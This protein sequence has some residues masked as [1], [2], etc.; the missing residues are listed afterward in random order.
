MRHR[1]LLVAVSLIALLLPAALADASS[2][3]FTTVE[4]P[5]ELLY[6]GSPNAALDTIKDLGATAIRVQLIWSQVAPDP[7]ATRAPSFNQTDPNAYPAGAWARWDAAIDGARARGLK[8][9][10]TITGPAPRWATAAKRDGLTKPDAEAFSK[11][12]SAAGRRYGSKVSWW[13]IWNEPNLGKLLKPIKG[14]QSATIYR[15]LYLQAYSGL[16]SVGVHAPILLGELAPIGNTFRDQGTIHPLQFLRKVLCL[17]SRWHKSRKCGKVPTQGFA[18]HPY[19]PR[20]GPTFQPQN[21]DDVTIGVLSRLV[22]ALDRAAKAGALPRR[23]PVYVSEFG[24]QSYPDTQFGVRL[25]TQSDFRSIGERMA[26]ANP[27]VKSFSQYLLRDDPPTPGAHGKFE[28]GLFLYKGDVP[29]PAY[30][31]FRLPLVVAKGKHG[32]AAL[33]GFVRPAHGRAGS[34]E[35]QVKDRRGGWKKLATQRYGGSGY[36]KRGATTKPGRQWRVVWTDPS[37]GTQWAG[38]A[39]VA[40]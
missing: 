13:S 8:V 1:I 25:A 7:D 40:R 33:W 17:D 3:Q 27:R 15:Q 11:F 26:W 22:K 24:V 31:G 14:L 23:L 10:L 18:M 6:S 39:T 30:Y 34:L 36:W 5:S 9:Y 12:A 35:I 21:R 38:S 28:S 20:F 4:A 32:H 37:T 2:R 29:K 19:T 16:R